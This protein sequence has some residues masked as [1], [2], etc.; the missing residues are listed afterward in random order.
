MSQ[1]LAEQYAEE[2]RPLAMKAR[3]IIRDLDPNNELA[4]LRIRAKKHEVL[5]AFGA[6]SISHPRD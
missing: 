2:M 6:F 1:E 5:T 4:Y 3:G